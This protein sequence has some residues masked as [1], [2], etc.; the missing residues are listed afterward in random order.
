MMD[1]NADKGELQQILSQLI[2]ERNDLL[3]RL[4]HLT[5]KYD[6]CVRDIS[7]DRADMERHNKQ[8]A[9]L[10]TA[11]II[12]QQLESFQKTRISQAYSEFK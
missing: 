1:E 10:I 11:K 9:K 12:F 4:E 7:N 5:R 6:E 2:V 3:S 8:H